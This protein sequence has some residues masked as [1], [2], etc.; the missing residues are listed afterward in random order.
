MTRVISKLALAGGL[1]AAAT[2]G[3]GTSAARAGGY[4]HPHGGHPRYYGHPTGHSHGW[5]RPPGQGYRVH[6]GVTR[7]APAIA[8]PVPTIVTAPALRPA[9]PSPKPL[10][11]LGTAI[12]PS[13]Q[14]RVVQRFRVSP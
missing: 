10:F 9:P 13:G 8:A 1:I 6:G 4:G 11:S 3:P 14:V 12:T 2:M 7:T 5:Y